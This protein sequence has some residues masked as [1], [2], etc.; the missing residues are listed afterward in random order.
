MIVLDIE[1]VPLGSEPVFNPAQFEGVKIPANYKDPEKIRVYTKDNLEKQ[2]TEHLEKEKEK[3]QAELTEW[4]KG[5]L[6]AVRSQIVCICALDTVTGS[7]FR[8]AS[9]DETDLLLKFTDWLYIHGST[10]SIFCGHNIRFDLQMLRTHAC[11]SGIL[12]QLKKILTFDKWARNIQDTMEIWAGV[13]YDDRTK[14]TDIAQYLGLEVG[15]GDTTGADIYDFYKAGRF[16]EIK[17]K[18]LNDVLLTY[19]VWK[20]IK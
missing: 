14:L 9:N 17:T 19:E 11:L 20:R 3:Y 7:I 8:W 2:V 4:K 16:E 18:C 6:K 12:E 13:R 5:A 1:T 10:G 15:N